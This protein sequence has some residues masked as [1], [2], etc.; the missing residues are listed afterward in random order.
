MTKYITKIP[1]FA[2]PAGPYAYAT[3]A[4]GTIYVAGQVGLTADGKLVADDVEGQAR[5]VMENLGKILH[6][7]GASFGDVL[8]ATIYLADVNDFGIVNSVYKEFFAEDE[9]PARETVAVAALPLGAKVEI[10]MIAATS[11]V[12]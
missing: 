2:P 7:A 10:S 11:S 4:A 12:R 9:Y 6:A 8:K 3:V 1:G 5:Q